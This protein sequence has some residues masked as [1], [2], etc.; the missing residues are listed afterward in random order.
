M[1]IKIVI[2][3]VICNKYF[4]DYNHYEI[5]HVYYIKKYYSII[6]TKI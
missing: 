3:N 4:Y 6:Y 1:Y 5:F 2:L